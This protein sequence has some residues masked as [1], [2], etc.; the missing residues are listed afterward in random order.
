MAKLYVGQGIE[1][2]RISYLLDSLLAET[3]NS[4]IWQAVEVHS[5]RTITIKL[6]HPRTTR[7]MYNLLKEICFYRSL[8]KA[9][10]TF[11]VPFY[12]HGHWQGHYA[13]VMARMDCDLSGIS[14][15]HIES[16]SFYSYQRRSMRLV[17]LWRDITRALN[18][19]HH[20]GYLHLD[21]KPGNILCNYDLERFYL[22]DFGSLQS[23]SAPQPERYSGSAGWM[24]PEQYCNKVGYGDPTY[25][26]TPATD[27]YALGLLL[28]AQITGQLPCQPRQQLL[29]G[30]LNQQDI[31]HLNHGLR[32]LA[33]PLRYCRQLQDKIVHCLMRNPVNRPARLTELCSLLTAIYQ[34]LEADSQKAHI[35]TQPF[36]TGE[37]TVPGPRQEARELH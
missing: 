34:T 31:G 14:F 1:L 32:Q 16:Q 23:I 28:Y 25:P 35:L 30:S 13:Y 36:P 11:F 17:R 20:H 15:D 3:D 33:L 5:G 24:A 9:V 7:A 22:G 8:P 27:I 26:M 10:Q 21:I 6:Y 37:R 18:C 19:L 4:Q 12:N 29:N 2:S